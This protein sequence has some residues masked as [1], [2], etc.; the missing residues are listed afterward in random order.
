M[1][2]PPEGALVTTKYDVDAPPPGQSSP[3]EDL[4]KIFDEKS[5]AIPDVY[6]SDTAPQERPKRLPWILGGAAGLL[7]ITLTT[8]G[9][10]ALMT[11]KAGTGAGMI[12]SSGPSLTQAR[13]ACTTAINKEMAD[14]ADG[15]SILGGL[16]KGTVTG[17]QVG[18]VQ[19]V[20]DLFEVRATATVR[21]EASDRVATG[22][23]KL[24]CVATPSGDSLT[25]KVTP[26]A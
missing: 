24:L 19:R 26:D 3:W 10:T 9:L 23:A 20:N 6:T 25:T 22:T 5:A 2:T 11:A 15:A 18:E 13:E 8:A 21:V 4:Q 17:I 12:V 16:V 14:R 1:P 7:V